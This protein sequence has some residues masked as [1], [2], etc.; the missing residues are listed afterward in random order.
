MKNLLRLLGEWW[1]GVREQIALV[2]FTH[3]VLTLSKLAKPT[4]QAWAVKINQS[5]DKKF[6]EKADLIQ[7]EIAEVLEIV[8]N[9]LR[10]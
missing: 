9:E 6:G 1:A 7:R 4:A 2:A 10:R 3:A 8:A 5:S